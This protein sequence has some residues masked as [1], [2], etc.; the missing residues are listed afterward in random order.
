MLR[1]AT[2]GSSFGASGFSLV[3][4]TRASS[5]MIGCGCVSS[6]RLSIVGQSMQRTVSSAFADMTLETDSLAFVF[7]ELVFWPT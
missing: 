7:P 2:L 6:T 1:P 4:V 5:F 3:L